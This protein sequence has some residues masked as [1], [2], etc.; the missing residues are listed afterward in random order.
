MNKYVGEMCP[1]C[2]NKFNDED[3]I[4]V[5]PVCGTP[6][7]KD[8]YQSIKHC[9]FEDK[10]SEG[11]TWS[12]SVKQEPSNAESDSPTK[13]R[14]V[15]CG[16]DNSADSIFCNKCGMPLDVENFN[17]VSGPMSFILDPLG[18]VDKNEVIKGIPVKDIAKYVKTS[19]PYY[20]NVFKRLK[21]INVGKFSF[22][23]FFFSGAW[24]LY[25]KQ[26]KLGSILTAIVGI[27]MILTTF[28]SYNYTQPILNSIFLSANLD[29]STAT[30]FTMSEALSKNLYSLQ[31][32]EILWVFAPFFLSVIKW[33]IM[34]FVGFR[35]NRIY[36]NNTIKEIEGFK[37]TS[38]SAQ[39]YNDKLEKN[40]GVNVSL[41]FCL[42]ICYLLI[43]WLPQF[44]I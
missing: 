19:V 34:L 37:Q 20:L 16:Q 28:I 29:I 42:F 12:P 33:F 3:N 36:F 31:P 23:G 41:G 26:Y 13:K 17:D 14:C 27:C 11:Y 1:V 6:Y 18:G 24:L 5:C 44:L 8:C 21:D 9:M 22:C 32:I 39:E 15:R 43:N 10:H 35:G 38:T 7:H 25:R 40:G 30:V 2:K 4:V